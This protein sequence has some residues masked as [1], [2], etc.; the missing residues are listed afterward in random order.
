M[1]SDSS[2]DTSSR[3]TVSA[4]IISKV[5][6]IPCLFRKR[7]TSFKYDEHA[8]V[9]MHR[10]HDVADGSLCRLSIENND[11]GIPV[12]LR[13]IDN[14]FSN[15]SMQDGAASQEESLII[16]QV[17]LSPCLAATIGL[18]WFRTRHKQCTMAFMEIIS[19]YSCVMEASHATV[20]EIG[21]LPPAPSFR[22]YFHGD[23]IDGYKQQRSID[24]VNVDESGLKQFFMYSRKYREHSTIDKSRASK[25]RQRLLCLGSIFA[26]SCNDDKSSTVRYYKVIGIHSPS[27][28]DSD[29]SGSLNAYHVSPSTQLILAANSPEDDADYARISRLPCPSM[30]KSYLHSIE[31]ARNA[32]A[33]ERFKSG[34]SES[35]SN[36]DIDNTVIPP[37]VPNAAAGARHPNA[38]QVANALYLLGKTDIMHASPQLINVI[39]SEDNHVSACVAEAADIMGMRYFRVEGLATF[40]AHYNFLDSYSNNSTE[41]KNRAL[42]GQLPDKLHGLAAAFKVAYRS[43]PCVLHITG[44][45]EELSSVTG[46]G[47]DADGRKEEERRILQVIHEAILES[48]NKQ[49]HFP[50][51]SIPQLIKSSTNV[52]VSS[53]CDVA[54]V[55][56]SLRPLPAGPLVSSLEQKSIVLSIPDANYAH[57]LWDDNID[58]TFNTISPMLMGMTAKDI[59]CLRQMFIPMWKEEK[60]K[61]P[62]SSSE[63]RRSVIESIIQSLLAEL[64]IMRSITRISKSSGSSSSVPLS[65]TS[66]PNVR[67]ED[68]G[69]LSSVRREIMDAVELPLKY[70]E[71]FERSRRSGILL[72]GPPGTGERSSV[73]W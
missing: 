64:E 49:R 28:L 48:S 15:N 67:W 65:S 57:H 42:T 45:D 18:H 60:K 25:P 8:T 17:Y 30:T 38:D 43:S 73:L 31:C 14:E 13:V 26:T 59:A 40:W 47:A 55:L 63:E 33:N 50:L 34:I 21:I 10:S 58:E 62:L 70:P 71:L 3:L 1:A 66:L 52:S 22:P 19:D 72:F 9:F 7:K 54:V 2:E 53:A 27:Q 5:P 36:A 24:H 4:H 51:H 23:K 6:A 61:H 46:H 11:C 12:I 39:G 41:Q 29:A 56:S 16:P 37:S 69:G 20:K 44:I 32:A 35:I 68:I